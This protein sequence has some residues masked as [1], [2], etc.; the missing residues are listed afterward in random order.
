MKLNL[1]IEPVAPVTWGLTNFCLLQVYER[2]EGR[3]LDFVKRQ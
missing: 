1:P 3:A 2:R